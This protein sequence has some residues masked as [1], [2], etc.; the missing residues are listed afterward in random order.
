MKG[1]D[2]LLYRGVCFRM[3]A[4]WPSGRASNSELRW[5]GFDFDPHWGVGINV[6]CP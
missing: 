1:A 2:K 3:G 4:W 6:L 5:S